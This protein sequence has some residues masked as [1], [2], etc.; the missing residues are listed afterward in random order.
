MG[1]LPRA[2]GP[3][4]IDSGGFTELSLHGEWTVPVRQ[5]VAEVRR[6]AEWIGMPRFAAQQ[7]WM[8]EPQILARTKKT[9]EEHQRLTLENYLELMNLAPDLPWAPVLQGWTWGDYL[10]HAEAYQRAGIDLSMPPVV[11]VGSICRRQGTLRAGAVLACLKDTKAKLHCFGMKVR[12]LALSKDL[13]C[14]ADSLAWS[15][16]ARKRPALPECAADH[17]SCQNCLRYALRWRKKLLD[18]L[19]VEDR[20]REEPPVQRLLF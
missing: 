12:G 19:G 17:R 11:G 15:F 14:S 10:R 2:R 13:V 20:P 7:D 9:V 18:A 5:Y 4:A 3:Y 6:F 1:S 16:A 8:V